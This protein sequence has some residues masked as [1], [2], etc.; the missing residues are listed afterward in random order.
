MK[1]VIGLQNEKKSE[2]FIVIM[3]VGNASRV[4]I[5]NKQNCNSV[6]SMYCCKYLAEL[7]AI[8][9]VSRFMVSGKLVVSLD[10]RI[11]PRQRPN[12]R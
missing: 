3:K 4:N 9:T 1:K 8:E 12:S 11:L 2:K 10:S 6:Q 7:D 5:P